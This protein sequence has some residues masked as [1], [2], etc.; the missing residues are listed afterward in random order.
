MLK[1]IYDSHSSLF[2]SHVFFGKVEMYSL[3]LTL[4]SMVLFGAAGPSWIGFTLTNI[5]LSFQK[6]HVTEKGF[7]DYHKLV[8]TF[9]KAR[10]VSEN[11]LRVLKIKNFSF[12]TVDSN[13]NYDTLTENFLSVVNIHALLK[14]KLFKA[15]QE[16]FMNKELQNEN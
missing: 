12:S 8:S 16:T 5:P 11:F 10:S 7:S 6:A 2:Q 4:F 1:S 3:R 13:Q 14:M 9:F 15:Y